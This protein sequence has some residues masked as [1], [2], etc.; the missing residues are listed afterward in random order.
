MLLFL[1]L[2]FATAAGLVLLYYT[3]DFLS[4]ALDYAREDAV[5]LSFDQFIAFYKSA[6]S[7]W[8]LGGYYV[9]YYV[10]VQERGHAYNKTEF[11]FFSSYRSLVKYRRWK[12]RN[13]KTQMEQERIRRTLSLSKCWSEDINESYTNA[14]G[15][16]QNMYHDNLEVAKRKEHEFKYL[17]RKYGFD[18]ICS[19]SASFI[20]NSIR[21]SGR[22]G[23]V[24]VVKNLNSGQMLDI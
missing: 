22:V 15:N 18:E 7:K 4:F 10:R 5:K 13:E 1:M 20:D 11:I 16:I 6:P 21:I 24:P 8:R 3:V 23:G 19:C 12:K 9:R 17:A 2:C 14:M